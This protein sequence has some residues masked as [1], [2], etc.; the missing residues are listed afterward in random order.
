MLRL[1][2]HGLDS[3]SV[4]PYTGRVIVLNAYAHLQ[5]SRVEEA[6]AACAAVKAATLSEAGCERYDYY[7]NVA[8]PLLIVFVEEWTSKPHLDAH[9]QTEHF[10]AF[11]ERVG[12]CLSGPPEIR[13]FESRLLE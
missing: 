3:Q 2:V 10:K 13:I 12:P 8:N 6:L 9:F 1:A 7:Q 11:F 5:E 4:A